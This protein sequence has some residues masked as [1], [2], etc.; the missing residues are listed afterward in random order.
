MHNVGPWSARG[1][2]LTVGKLRP[3]FSDARRPFAAL[4]V[5]H[6][7]HVTQIAST[8]YADRQPRVAGVEC[9]RVNGHAIR[10]VAG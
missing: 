4:A 5:A 3:A 9:H 10:L 7:S 2:A 6:A 8:E 1:G